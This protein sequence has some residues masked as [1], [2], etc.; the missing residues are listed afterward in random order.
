MRSGS[1]GVASLT[2]GSL[3]RARF[4]F[5]TTVG[6]GGVPGL[7]GSGR[8]IAP[9]SGRLI[10]PS[11]GRLIARAA[12]RADAAS[13]VSPPECEQFVRDPDR[14]TADQLPGAGDPDDEAGNDQDRDRLI[15]AAIAV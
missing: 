5:R 7:P 1:G 14:G 3:P 12:P 2:V 10:A 15:G 13:R 8:L 6:A 11:G 4:G 9:G